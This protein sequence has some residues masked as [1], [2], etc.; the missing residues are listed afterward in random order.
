MGSLYEASYGF[1]AAPD[2]WKPPRELAIAE[3]MHAGQSRGR[4]LV[5]KPLVRSSRCDH[6]RK[7]LLNI[8]APNMDPK[9]GS[10]M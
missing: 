8:R 5:K 1:E 7:G 3:G 6:T 10:L 9:T 2:F 4:V